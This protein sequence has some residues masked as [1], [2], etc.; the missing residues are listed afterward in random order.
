MAV[1]GIE[2]AQPLRFQRWGKTAAGELAAGVLRPAASEILRCDTDPNFPE[3][4]AIDFEV[5]GER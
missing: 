2:T 5:L 3:R 1:E 4:G